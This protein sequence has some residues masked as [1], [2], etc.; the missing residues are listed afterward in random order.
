V[1]DNPKGM[2]FGVVKVRLT[3]EGRK[4]ILFRVYPFE[5]LTFMSHQQTVLRLPNDAINL[6]FTD[7]DN[8]AAFF[9]P[10]V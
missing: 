5:F 9:L 8:H 7:K 3:G 4:N 1:G 10:T 6:A 2:E